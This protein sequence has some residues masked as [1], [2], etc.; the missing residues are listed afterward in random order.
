MEWF[1]DLWLFISGCNDIGKSLSSIADQYCIVPTPQ[2]LVC[3]LS[4]KAF[5]LDTRGQL[6]YTCIVS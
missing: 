4:P 1:T 3:A 5:V 6:G 2:D